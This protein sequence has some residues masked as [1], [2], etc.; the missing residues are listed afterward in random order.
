MV[1]IYVP[2]LDPVLLL[3]TMHVNISCSSDNAAVF[4][5]IINPI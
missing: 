2:Y 3:D 5:W 1:A 4:M